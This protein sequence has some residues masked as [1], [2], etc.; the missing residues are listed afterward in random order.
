M[1]RPITVVRA[2]KNLTLRLRFIRTNGSFRFMTRS[3]VRFCL[4]RLI[5]ADCRREWTLRPT[6]KNRVVFGGRVHENHPCPCLLNNIT[7][8]GKVA[9]IRERYFRSGPVMAVIPPEAVVGGVLVL[10][11]ELILSSFSLGQLVVE[12][13]GK[14]LPRFCDVRWVEDIPLVQKRTNSL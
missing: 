5:C 13:K 4:V 12:R 8:S 9:K 6:T 11:S 2:S 3:R 7:G 14:L 10:A 1:V